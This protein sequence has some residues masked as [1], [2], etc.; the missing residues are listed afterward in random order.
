MKASLCGLLQLASWGVLEETGVREE[1]EDTEC[2]PLCVWQCSWYRVFASVSGL[3]KQSSPSRFWHLLPTLPLP[4][5]RAFTSHSRVLHCVCSFSLCF[6]PSL[7]RV[8][9]LHLP[10]LVSWNCRNNV[11]ET[12]WLKTIEMYCLTVLGARS[13]KSGCWECSA[14][15]DTYHSEFFLASS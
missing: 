8:H 13:P 10:G 11:P 7:W 6:P 1:S 5:R 4:S 14:L 15:S 9:L 2:I 3:S 12:E